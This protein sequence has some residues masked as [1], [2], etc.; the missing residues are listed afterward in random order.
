MFNNE[1]YLIAQVYFHLDHREYD[2]IIMQ[3]LVVCGRCQMLD[4]FMSEVVQKLYKS[5]NNI[6]SITFLFV[7]IYLLNITSTSLTFLSIS[8][9]H[10]VFFFLVV[11]SFLWC[12][13]R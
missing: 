6:L 9:S 3:G 8:A 7:I 2:C 5:A 12:D 10:L 13:V 11:A 1:N 4:I